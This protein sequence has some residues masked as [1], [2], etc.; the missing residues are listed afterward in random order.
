MLLATAAVG[1][2]KTRGEQTNE[3]QTTGVVVM[4]YIYIYT[5]GV[6]PKNHIVGPKK[7]QLYKILLPGNI[8]N[9]YTVV[10]CIQRSHL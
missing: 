7:D 4:D 10:S 9:C 1:S 2:E 3:K 6:G 8:A 5:L